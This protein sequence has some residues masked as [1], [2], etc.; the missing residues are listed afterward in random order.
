MVRPSRTVNLFAQCAWAIWDMVVTDI[1][2]NGDVSRIVRL[3][4]ENRPSG[5]TKIKSL[6][7][8][9]INTDAS[10]HPRY[11]VAAYA[12]W[13]VSDKGRIKQSGPLRKATSPTDAELQCIANALHVLLK[14]DIKGMTRL[15]I[16]SDALYGFERVGRKKPGTGGAVAK[17]LRQLREKYIPATRWTERFWEFRHVKAHS[18]V[19]DKRSWVNEWCDQ[20]AKQE[21]RRLVT[22]KFKKEND[23]LSSNP[24]GN[25]ST[26]GRDLQDGVRND[27]PPHEAIV[28]TER[29][30]LQTMPK[31]R[32]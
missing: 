3:R 31:R 28:R 20:M 6:M 1:T 7:I 9:T 15:V 21:M 29:A 14:S 26:G 32:R 12:F 17:L 16:N 30:N 18:G 5:K 25:V 4:S 19:G 11:K 2:N 10:F 22:L 27:A 8:V 24:D 23:T 13:I